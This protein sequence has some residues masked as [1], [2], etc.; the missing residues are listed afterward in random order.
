MNFPSKE[1]TLNQDAGTLNRL[2]QANV[3]SESERLHF[4]RKRA[5]LTQEDLSKKTG[6]IRAQV[7]RHVRGENYLYL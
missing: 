4:F 2:N 6:I 3:L 5:G 7:S 1:L